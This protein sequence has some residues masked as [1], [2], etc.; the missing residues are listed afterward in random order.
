V[1]LDPVH[2]CEING[3]MKK[4]NSHLKA[5]IFFFVWFPLC[6]FPQAYLWPTN[7]SDYLSS[8]FCEFREGHY[9]SAI[10]I[11]TWNTEGYPCYAVADGF[12][13]RLRI[14]PFGYGKVLYLQLED[15]N[16]AVYAHLQKFSKAIDKQ[17]REIQFR[18]KKY[19]L[20]WW[21][22]NLKVKKGDIIAYTGH[23]GIG[24]PHLHFEI[25]NKKDNPVNPLV[26]YSRIKDNIRPKLLE[27]AVIPLTKTAT[28]N[29]SFLPKTFPVTHIKDGIYVIKEPLYTYGKIGLAIR[30]YDL[31]DDVYNKYGF[32][33]TDLEVAGQ[34]IFQIEY[35]ELDF[36]TTE[37]IY[38]EIYYPYWAE[39]KQVFNKLYLE[40]F[41]PLSFYNRSLATDGSMDVY[42]NPISFNI[43]VSDFKKNR[44]IISGELLP[45]QK[46]SIKV[47]KAVRKKFWAYVK[48]LAPQIRDLKF[49]TGKNNRTWA[50]VEY[51]EILEGNI[52]NSEHGLWARVGLKDSSSLYLKIEVNKKISRSIYFGLPDIAPEKLY[53]PYVLGKKLIVEI[54]DLNP[55]TQIRLLDDQIKLGTSFP[56]G[57][58]R[59]VIIPGRYIT[60]KPTALMITS[61]S[62][63]TSV[64]NLN[65]DALYP[66]ETTISSWF[67][68]ALVIQSSEGSVMDTTLFTVEVLD[69][70]TV[71][72]EFPTASQIF[73]ISPRNFPIFNSVSIR[74]Q[75]DSLPAWG[76]WSIFK[77][78]GED[79]I[80]YLSSKI[81]S[82]ALHFTTR[83]SSLGKFVIAADTIPPE[84]S[85]IKPINGQTYKRS[86]E[87]QIE[88]KDLLS[89][90]GDEEDISLIMD[91]NYVLPEWDPEE[92][93]LTGILAND[94]S[95][96]NHVLTVSIGDRSGNTT[97][98]AVY[99]KI[100]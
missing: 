64:M 75:A 33:H 60:G 49:F 24:V 63:N 12:I 51:F 9:H 87:I 4:L 39:K 55:N 48:F 74:I 37:H 96:G 19:R 70:D 44:S 17:V 94:L 90:I 68:S 81:D 1:I 52:A 5:I 71:L 88:I 16:T 40:S 25:R 6:V 22:K 95:V 69:I 3:C 62:F 56:E 34:K 42:E 29:G 100:E 47:I 46:Y 32:S 77:T 10:D 97:R 18:N 41:N 11:K 53:Q 79:K 43:T 35:D 93:L 58:N 65:F 67:D 92:D 20:N 99:F 76:H 30:G 31:A 59:Q 8:S 21:P 82:G 2:I 86:P 36:S 15:G 84:V 98:K 73:E 45:A 14:S 38:S 26:Y 57:V 72:S 61:D 83:T 85:I 7:A 80:S 66:N 28:I 78:N 54:P 50:P 13:K 27:L 91:G 23:T 89:G